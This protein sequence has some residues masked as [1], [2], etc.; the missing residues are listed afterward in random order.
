M[1][2][3][4]CYPREVP[5]HL[6]RCGVIALTDSGQGAHKVREPTMLGGMISLGL[7]TGLKRVRMLGGLIA[8][9]LALGLRCGSDRGLGSLVGGIGGRVSGH[10]DGLGCNALAT[11]R[12]PLRSNGGLTGCGLCLNGGLLR[13]WRN[14]WGICRRSSRSG[15]GCHLECQSEPREPNALL[16]RT[17]GLRLGGLLDITRSAR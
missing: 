13:R 1:Y 6:R 11:H 17:R 8:P 10:M 4:S 15:Q 12:I 16:A 7:R 2:Q 9:R 3:L 14:S 5:G